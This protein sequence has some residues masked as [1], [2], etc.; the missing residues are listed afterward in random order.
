VVHLGVLDDSDVLCIVRING[1]ADLGLPTG[2]GARVPAHASA[3]G[4]A[5]LAFSPRSVLVGLL[6]SGLRALTPY[7]IVFPAVL[8]QDLAATCR[9][10]VAFDR[11]EAMVGATAVAAPIL[12]PGH[13]VLGALSVTGPTPRFDPVQLARAVR[14]A[15]AGIA[16]R[17]GTTHPRRRP[18]TVRGECRQHPVP[19]PDVPKNGT[20]ALPAGAREEHLFPAV[21]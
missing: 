21:V 11:E 1:H 3:L 12:G 10:G 17:L 18:A 4:K 7:T 14:V 19:R 5:M 2:D 9:T 15:A 16:R 8:V 20:V 6:A 13:L